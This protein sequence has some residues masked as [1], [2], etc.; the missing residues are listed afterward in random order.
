MDTAPYQD[1]QTMY[2]EVRYGVQR[3]PGF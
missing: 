2:S 3:Q 1:V